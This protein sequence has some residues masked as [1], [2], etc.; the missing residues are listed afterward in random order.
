M[1]PGKDPVLSVGMALD[2]AD[3]RGMLQRKPVVK[4]QWK[5]QLFMDKRCDAVVEFLGI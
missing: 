2:E 3:R 5:S 1:A 4:L